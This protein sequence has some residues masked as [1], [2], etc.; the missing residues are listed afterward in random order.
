VPPRTRPG[1]RTILTRTAP[2]VTLTRIQSGVGILTFETARLDAVGDLHLGCAYRLRSSLS[3][4]LH[5]IGTPTTAPPDSTRPVIIFE[6]VQQ[7]RFTLDLTQ[8]RDIDRLVIYAFSGGR[9]PPSWLVTLVATTFG[10]ARIE[11]PLG[12]L[13]PQGVVVLMSLYNIAG[14]FVL[15]A[16]MDEIAGTTRDACAAYGFDDITW[17]D[18][19]TPLV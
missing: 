1:I 16:E 5:D 7:N 15:R 9:T 13:P 12:Q 3:S 8:S 17:L 19:W 6:P 18:A 14:E 2:T 4:A 10:Q 11:M